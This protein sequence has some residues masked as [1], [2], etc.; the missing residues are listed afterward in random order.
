MKGQEEKPVYYIYINNGKKLFTS[1]IDLA[2]KRSDEGTEP[3]IYEEEE[4]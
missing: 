4:K 3:Q 2:W 1:N